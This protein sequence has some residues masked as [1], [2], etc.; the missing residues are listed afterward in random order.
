MVLYGYT[1]QVK[2]YELLENYPSRIAG[3]SKVVFKKIYL[4]SL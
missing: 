3:K 4:I 1:L 2:K